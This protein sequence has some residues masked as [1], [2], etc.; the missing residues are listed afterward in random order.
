MGLIFSKNDDVYEGN[1][2]IID[3][4]DSLVGELS[5]RDDYKQTL[6][7]GYRDMSW[8]EVCDKGIELLQL[9]KETSNEV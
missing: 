3:A 9:L 5:M 1:W 4:L 6:Y 8:D 7:P 2:E